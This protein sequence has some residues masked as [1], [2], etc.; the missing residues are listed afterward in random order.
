MA[1]PASNAPNSAMQSRIFRSFF[2]ALDTSPLGA[3][4]EFSCIGDRIANMI[5]KRD[6]KPPGTYFS[7]PAGGDQMSDPFLNGLIL[8]TRNR[9]KVAEAADIVKPVLLRSIGELEEETGKRL[10]DTV[11]DGE[12]Y[13]AN[14]EKK[15]RE[16][17]LFFGLPALADDSGLEV[18]ALDGRPGVLSARY[19]G[20]GVSSE[21]QCELIL[22]ELTRAGAKDSPAR[23]VCCI[24]LVFPAGERRLFEGICEGRIHE[25]PQGDGGFGYDPIFYLPE[26][27]CTMAEVGAEPRGLLV[28]R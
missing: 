23:F 27:E 17:A 11:E 8:A 3:A 10:P 19:G 5:G 2:L 25:R 4:P 20:P 12:T 9:H 6:G 14:A 28:V 13:A 22:E 1:T 26:R 24:A 18:A 16:A 7:G 21:R 15:A